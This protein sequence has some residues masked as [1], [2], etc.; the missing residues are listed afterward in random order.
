M[1]FE[2]LRQMPIFAG[3]SDEQLAALT[4]Q[5]DEVRLEPGQMLFY[6]GDP[7]QGLFVIV[8]GELEIIKR[9]GGQTVTLARRAAAES[10]EKKVDRLGG[11]NVVVAAVQAGSFVGETSLLTGL[12]HSAAA[13]ATVPTVCLQ[14][15]VELF[16]GLHNSPIVQL[17]IMTM[18]ERLRDTESQVQQHQKLSALGKMAAGLAHELNNPASA[19]LRAATQLPQTLEELQA[20]TLRLYEAKLKPEQVAFLT[21]LQSQLIGRLENA[22]SLD[23]LTRSDRED[24][25]MNWCD[26]ASV[27]ESWALAPILASANVTVDE[28]EHLRAVLGADAVGVALSWLES[29]LTIAG[30]GHTIKQSATRVADLVKA[31]KSYT[32]MDQAPQQEIDVHDGLD[33]TLMVLQHRLN[34]ITI[35]REY[36]RQLPRITAYGSE[37]NQVWTILLDNAA[38]ALA[39]QGSICLRTSLENDH[40]LVEFTDNGPGIP[41][42]LHHRLFEPFFTTKPVGQG[43]GLGLSIARRIVVERHN[44]MINAQSRPGETCFQVFL[45]TH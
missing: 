21:A 15:G 13:R 4:T 3:F 38:D 32:Y 34:A 30:L 17:V 12:P 41:P 36:S 9:V 33:S 43:T 24:L 16:Q 28:L 14:Y 37:L 6:E 44:G 31:V 29:A 22:E 23:P 45:P 35:T 18:V 27:E 26:D 7:P 8:E 2:K 1:A 19:N 40:V 39:G 5:S 25:I 10:G 42:E 20:R 11:Q